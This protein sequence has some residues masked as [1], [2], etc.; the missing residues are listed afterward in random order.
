MITNKMAKI[1]IKFILIVH[2]L[3][4]NTYLNAADHN[5]KIW[6]EDFKISAV[7][8]GVSK[9]SLCRRERSKR[10]ESMG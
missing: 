10:N 4:L 2:I 9:N 6:L 7:K 3:S 1:I 8:K 5:F